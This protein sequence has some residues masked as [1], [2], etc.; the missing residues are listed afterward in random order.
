MKGDFTRDTFDSKK[1][2]S[3]VRMQQGRVSLDADW[4]EQVDIATHRVE[5]EAADIIGG[6]GAAAGSAGFEIGVLILGASSSTAAVA[7]T[8]AAA[9]TIAAASLAPAPARTAAPSIAAGAVAIDPHPFDPFPVPGDLS[10]G[11]G[12]Y[13]V[14]GILCENE[15]AVALTR[16]PDLPG[17]T[18]LSAGLYVIYLDVWKRHLTALDDPSI[19][20]AALGGPDTATRTKTVWQ[21]KALR[22]SN[23]PKAV[24][25]STSFDDWDTLVAPRN[26]GLH[27][28][29]NPAS[30]NDNPCGPIPS[31]AGFRGLENQ[32]YRVEIHTPGAVPGPATFKW[33]RDNGSIEALWLDQDKS[34][35]KVSTTGRDSVLNIAA[36]QW[37]ELTDDTHELNGLPGTL[38]KVTVVQGDLVTIDPGNTVISRAKFPINPRL[39]RWDSPGEMQVPQ[40]ASDVYISLESGIEVRFDPDSYKT[41]DYWLIPARSLTADVEWPGGANPDALPPRGIQHHYCRLA[42]VSVDRAGAVKVLQD[43][44]CIFPRL[45]Q[46][47]IHITDIKK[48]ISDSHASASLSND[49]TVKVAGILGGIDVICDGPVGPVGP[50]ASTQI[51]RAVCSV[52][53]Q[54]PFPRRP[55]VN[56]AAYE[57]FV[58]AADVTASGNVISWIP[59]RKEFLEELPYARVMPP[60]PGILARLLLKG[61]Y[62]WDPTPPAANAPVRYLDGDAFARTDGSTDWRHPSGDGKP[63]GDFEMWFWLTAEP[64]PLTFEV[65]AKANDVRI[66]GYTE[67]V[68]DI[69]LQGSGGTPT[70]IGKPVPTY[71]I[72]LSADRFEISSQAQ[73]TGG[74]IDAV[75]L[76]GGTA[77]LSWTSQPA[78]NLVIGR[79][80]S[81]T[82]VLF[83]DVP[84][85]PP[86]FG[87]ALVAV[88]KNVRVNLAGKAAAGDVVTVTV[89]ITGGPQPVVVKNP[90]VIVAN[91]QQGLSSV[92]AVT[93]AGTPFRLVIKQGTPAHK[94]LLARAPLSG[95]TTDFYLKFKEGFVNAF[96]VR[97]GANAQESGFEGPIPLYSIGSVP[98]GTRLRARF[99]N[100]PA[101]VLLFVTIRDALSASLVQA[102]LVPTDVFGGGAGSVPNPT[103]FTPDTGGLTNDH[104]IPLLEVPVTNETGIV[105]WEWVSTNLGPPRDVFFGVVVAV[106]ALTATQTIRIS[107]GLAPTNP[108]T[109]PSFTESAFKHVDAAISIVTP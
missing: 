16:Q 59:R 36:G 14:D 20:E 44:R 107:A 22:I 96:R 95:V 40:P 94:D 1:H 84:L 82:T 56:V 69:V 93:A 100:V 89:G 60:D 52:T 19:R 3:S 91:A 13:Y 48:K 108:A 90:T 7:S 106:P 9:S 6:C 15:S 103:L 46:P 71:N 61:N 76:I 35:L 28:R 64:R 101:G 105:E 47:G 63:G 99:E 54:V 42:L 53:V 86:V 33:S 75:L 62:I 68:A 37:V 2:Y 49:E 30:Q 104:G 41:G 97:K 79:R 65:A 45:C 66:E 51:S 92:D 25:C 77:A 26:P 50:A 32:L 29:A 55:G 109:V 4:N 87:E 83:P 58:V 57:Q 102:Q 72:T 38:V 39:R 43:C 21:V 98:T 78:S 85:D 18:A 27:A 80:L 88:I 74:L 23:P 5:T 10:I 34:V 8:A 12:H 24:Y 31:G 73:D 17:Q 11:A 81:P 67:L 70:E